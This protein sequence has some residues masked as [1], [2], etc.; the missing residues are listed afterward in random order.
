M[1]SCEHNRSTS[2]SNGDQKMVMFRDVHGNGKPMGIPL[3]WEHKYAKHIRNG[4][5]NRKCDNAN[6]NG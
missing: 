4:N 6:E 5:G 2:G 1:T 3:E